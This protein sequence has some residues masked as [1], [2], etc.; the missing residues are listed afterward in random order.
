[1][2]AGQS[3]WETALRSI[4]VGLAFV[5]AAAIVLFIAVRVIEIA[6]GDDR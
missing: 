6:A 4:G 3:H 1:L 2:G 5:A